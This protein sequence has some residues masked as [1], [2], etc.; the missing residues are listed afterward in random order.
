[1]TDTIAINIT[2][3]EQV[4]ELPKCELACF[5]LDTDTLET[6]IEKYERTYRISPEKGYRWMNYLYLEVT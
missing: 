2:K 6:A 5:S 1:M 4:R 3:I